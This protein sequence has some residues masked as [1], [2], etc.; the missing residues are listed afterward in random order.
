MRFRDAVELLILSALWGASFLFMRI[1]SPEFGPVV[2]M[3]LRVTIAALF[4]LPIFLLRSDI[5]ELV[6]HWKEVAVLGTVN[7]AIPFC[8]LAY[9]TLYVTGGFSAILNATAPLW[10]AI[11]AWLW[12]SE[13]LDSSRVAGLLTGF[14]GVIILVWNKVSL[15][16]DGVTL[17]ILAAIV[18]SLFYGIGATYTRKYVQGIGSLAI[19]TGSQAAAAVVL[20]PGSVM[21]WPDGPVSMQA[22][23]SLV[24]MAIASTGIAY[25][26][27]FRLIAN[28]GPS[29]AI[30]VT[31]LAPAF[32]VLWGAIF[33]D[34][35]L[36]TTMVVGCAIIFV[37]TAIATGV[38]SLGGKK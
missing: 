17:A 15:D 12:L 24:V 11:I 37:G 2:L 36:T 28:V 4:L 38:L 9:S 27:Y 31:Y 26:L 5:S 18:A 23:V 10:T 1:A 19:A 7:S 6:T 20:L 32:A 3:Q 34:E 35:R 25:I 16:F 30:T 13:R 21:L 14:A 8:L 29:K 33:I 22:W